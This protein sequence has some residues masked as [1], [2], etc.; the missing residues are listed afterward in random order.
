MSTTDIVDLHE[1]NFKNYGPLH[2]IYETSGP[3]TIVTP[4]G[5][6]LHYHKALQIAHDWNMYGNGDS[7][8]IQETELA[9][10]PDSNIIFLG[11]PDENKLT[12]AFLEFAISDVSISSREF[13]IAGH[14][15]SAKGTGII[16]HQPWRQRHMAIVIAGIDE[17]GFSTATQ[18]IP[19]RTGIMVSD[20]GKD[21]IEIFL[22]DL[23]CIFVFWL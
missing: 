20:W 9:D 6:V 2:R 17:D 11:G 4:P 10:L 3:L 14:R 7:R 15:Y 23:S 12:A 19:K 16:F 21:Q 18:L 22:I 8:I 1:R 5:S 13:N